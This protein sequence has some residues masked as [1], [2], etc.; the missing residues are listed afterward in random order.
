MSEKKITYR[1]SL[2]RHERKVQA[3]LDAR[4]QHMRDMKVNRPWAYHEIRMTQIY[5]DN[6]VGNRTP[7]PVTRIP[8]PPRPPR[9]PDIRNTPPIIDGEATL[10]RETVMKGSTRNNLRRLAAQL[11]R[12][13]G[14]F[15]PLLRWIETILDI[16]EIVNRQWHHQPGGVPSAPGWDVAVRCRGGPGDLVNI[17][18]WAAALNACPAPYYL[19]QNASAAGSN[20]FPYFNYDRSDQHNVFP[21]YH[22]G[23]PAF[24]LQRRAGTTGRPNLRMS[25]YTNTGVMPFVPNTP[26]V[27]VPY[28]PIVE[29][30]T[31]K[32]GPEPITSVPKPMRRPPVPG[33]PPH[34]NKRPPRGTK[35]RK[36]KMPGWLALAANAAWGA[37]EAGDV[38]E[39]LF[40][41]LPGNIKRNTVATGRTYGNARIG[42]GKPYLSLTDKAQAVWKH[43]D[44]IDMHQAVPELI[45]NHLIDHAVG[46]TT[47]G[48]GD[49]LKKNG[50][51]IKSW[52]VGPGP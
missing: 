23:Y 25:P 33:G 13:F 19:P 22:M 49:F 18:N 20:S 39:I 17:A 30:V 3:A 32:D 11:L 42:V 24:R 5:R 1:S 43:A 6:P 21:S 48:A 28:R 27:P 34:R 51:T 9:S 41:A 31:A 12:K 16:S 46:S 10:I 8:I 40:D 36:F 2:T 35:E 50:V 4:R 47:G 29:A 26:S 15:H 14:R 7:V 52:G 38:I 37:T 45:K 44:K